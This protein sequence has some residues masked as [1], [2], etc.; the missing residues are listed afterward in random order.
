[1]LIDLKPPSSTESAPGLLTPNV[2]KLL[3]KGVLG[4]LGLLTR[5]GHGPQNSTWELDT[6]LKSESKGVYKEQST[7]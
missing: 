3:I 7:T 2:K 4:Y 6:L 1:M 5:I